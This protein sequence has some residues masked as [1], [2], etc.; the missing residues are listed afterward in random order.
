V[1]CNH[2]SC[3]TVL[4]TA[5][6]ELHCVLTVTSSGREQ[7]DVAGNIIIISLMTH[8]VTLPYNTKDDSAYWRWHNDAST[9][10][11]SKV[12]TIAAMKPGRLRQH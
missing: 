11:P 1:S 6:V 8:R 2:V 9:C 5:V 10:L 3:N 12:M 4:E 7:E